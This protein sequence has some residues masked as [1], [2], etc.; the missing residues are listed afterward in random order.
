MRQRERELSATFVATAAQRRID[1]YE[2]LYE[3]IQEAIESDSMTLDQYKELRR[4]LVY[5]RKDI[6][7]AA[8][9]ALKTLAAGNRASVRHASDGVVQQLAAV[10]ESIEESL[11]LNIVDGAALALRNS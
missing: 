3:T 1:A 6:R 2:V 10:Q 9:E 11:G 5:I 8:V 4:H 7:N